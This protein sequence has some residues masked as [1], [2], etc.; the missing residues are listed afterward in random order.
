MREEKRGRGKGGGREGEGYFRF[1]NLR[2]LYGGQPGRGL[3]SC[4]FLGGVWAVVDRQGFS[5]GSF[6]EEGGS[7]IDSFRGQKQGLFSCLFARRNAADFA[8]T[9]W[10]PLRRLDN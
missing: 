9:L 7:G 10:S 2:G 1:R 5:C 3:L 8:V 4:F 6:E